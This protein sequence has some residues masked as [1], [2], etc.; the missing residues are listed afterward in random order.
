MVRWLLNHVSSPVLLLIIVGAALAIGAAAEWWQAHQRGRPTRANDMV[1]LTVEFV[2][3]AYAIMVGFVI[4]NLWQDQTD[5]REA[6]SQEASALRDIATLSEVL[7]ADSAR[8]AAAVRT[9][10]DVV[11]NDE[12]P[13]LRN[14]T[15]S[16]RGHDAADGVL[17]AITAVDASDPLAD[18]LQS[19]MIDSFKEFTGLRTHR[20][21]LADV[22]LARE[23]WLLV[24]LASVSLILLVA[25][26]ESEGSKWHIGATMVVAATI[27]TILFVVVA[28]S[29]PF[30]GDVSVS[31]SPFI[32]LARSL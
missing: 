30:S 8:I 13:L 25:A 26:F 5:A 12:W 29:Y 22:Q 24:I 28:L 7:P 9:Y 32:E 19:S 10:C 20:V 15:R 3:L 2:G 4:V 14:G 27:G 18:K 6:V 1:T 17:R 16:E 11:V 31:P 23:L 21:A